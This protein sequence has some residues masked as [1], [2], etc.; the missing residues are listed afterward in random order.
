MVASFWQFPAADKGIAVQPDKQQIIIAKQKIQMPVLLELDAELTAIPY[1]EQDQVWHQA[2]LADRFYRG[3]EQLMVLLDY[4]NNVAKFTLM[5]HRDEFCLLIGKDRQ[6]LLEQS[7]T[8]NT[9]LSAEQLRQ[10]S[11]Q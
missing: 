3:S 4:C 8:D 9:F 7:L 6:I 2:N 11:T 5:N 1:F 10:W